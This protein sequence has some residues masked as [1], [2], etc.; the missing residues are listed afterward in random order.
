MAQRATGSTEVSRSDL[1]LLV[2]AALA[3]STSGPFG[4]VA[5]SIAPTVTASARTGLAAI[6]LALVAPRELVTSLARLPF[7][8]RTGVLLAGALLG[9]HFALFL[10]GL[11]KTS[12]AAA[13]S[14]VSLEPLSVVL[15]AFVAFRIRPT[16]REV[17]G[18]VIATFGA[19]VVASAAG[20]G[21]HRLAGDLMVLGA[22]V[23]F[24]AYV[25]AARGLRDALPAT[26]YAA[27]VYGTA[28]LVLLP[29]A[30]PSM[31]ASQDP[32]PSPRAVASVL[33]LALVPTLIGHTLVQ[34]AAR[35]VP[36]VLVGLVSPGE[37]LGAL[38]LGAIV[39]GTLPTARESA[40]AGLILAGA[41]LAVVKPARSGK[42]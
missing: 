15:A 17:A 41:T 1:V 11:A 27:A 12:L 26:P 6:V 30:V 4:K 5:A 33:G 22:V 23:L 25:A 3:F 8:H 21:E 28:S 29:L 14:L 18:L 35:H 20:A 9:A 10:G 38:A 7:R 19:A 24:G 39:M 37:T 42:D 2:L 40:G 34:R 32:V 16:R 13:V 31:L 36:P